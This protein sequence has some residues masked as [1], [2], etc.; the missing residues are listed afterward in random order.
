[1]E[2]GNVR[3]RIGQPSWQKMMGAQEIDPPFRTAAIIPLAIIA[4]IVYLVFNGSNN[5]GPE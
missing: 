3:G 1:M 5:Y 2:L 4:S